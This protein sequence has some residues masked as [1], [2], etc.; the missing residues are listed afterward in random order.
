MGSIIAKEIV[1]KAIFLPYQK[2]MLQFQVFIKK[3]I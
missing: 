3:Y 2:K 1:K